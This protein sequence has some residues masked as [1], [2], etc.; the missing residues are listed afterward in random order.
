MNRY[1]TI[2]CTKMVLAVMVVCLHSCL[3]TGNHIADTAI[4]I[5][6]QLPVP[7][8]FSFSGFFF[9]K[10]N[11]KK[12]VR[13]ILSL[14]A[15]WLI[16][17]WPLTITV[18]RDMTFMQAIGQ[19]LFSGA[20]SVAWFLVA[21]LWCM[22][23]TSAV[24]HIRCKKVAVT[25]LLALGIGLYILCISQFCYKT[26][27]NS[28]IGGTIISGYK[29]IFHTIAWSFPQGLVFFAVGYLFN[30]YDIRLRK[31]TAAA[32]AVPAIA[33]Y[34]AE[35]WL[36]I[37]HGLGNDIIATFAMMPAVPA[38][39]ALILSFCCPTPYVTQGKRLREASTMLYL[40]HPMIM[41]LLYRAFG[42]TGGLMR[43]LPTLAIF[44]IMFAVYL[45]LRERRGFQWLRYAC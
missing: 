24:M 35:A 18:Y 9:A 23:I 39:T 31:S 5:L 14:Y 29:S 36:I 4:H 16:V 2:N 11:L 32:L 41:F 30:L 38:L 21:L 27:L 20:F 10:G 43:L 44:T 37:N 42:I 7:L 33:L 6:L 40:S 25:L 12:S 26:L 22:I 8:F 13:H 45:R 3:L 19:T 28:G 1:F 17:C 15:F 34:A